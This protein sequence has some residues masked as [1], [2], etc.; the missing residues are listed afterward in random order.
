M[1]EQPPISADATLDPPTKAGRGRGRNAGAIV[2]ASAVAALSSLVITMF[3]NWTLDRPNDHSDY[4]EFIA[5]WSLLF[6][7][8]G[9][10]AG[11]QNE[12]TRAVGAARLA[13]SRDEARDPGAP[14]L[15]AGLVLGL[16]AAVLVVVS[17]PLWAPQMLPT[18]TWLVVALIA[19]ATLLYGG[20]ISL[21]GAL[22]GNENWGLYAALMAAE[23]LFRLIAV[24]AVGAL[25]GSLCGLEIATISA[26]LV[27]LVLL[28]A[29]PTS[30]QA[31][32]SRAD[33]GLGRL[34]TNQL[35]TIIAAAATAVLITGFPAVMNLVIPHDPSEP[36]MSATATALMLTRSPIM[37]PLLA[38]QGVAISNFLKQGGGVLRG[39]V[40]PL[41][42]LGLVGLIAAP[43]AAWLGPWLLRVLFS[44]M[45]VGRW[46]FVGLVIA[47]TIVAWLT[48]TGTAILAIGD[49][50]GY[51]AGWLL[52]AVVAVALLTVPLSI[53][54]RVILALAVG[55]LL[56]V[57]LHLM[58]IHRRSRRLAVATSTDRPESP[59]G[60]GQTVQPT[61]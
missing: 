10:I 22:A 49:H 58:R 9:V 43:L 14:V 27:W 30:R 25:I 32:G 38:F 48:L 19:L 2:A 51:L 26:V 29:S 39:L 37:I 35:L 60:Y 45:Q 31:A 56:G 6:G 59:D 34:L 21:S 17:A 52:A 3:A 57:G 13:R 54:G 7:V 12:I 33:V 24:A 20:H 53:P 1:T 23:A 50:A 46:T 41:G 47:S 36:T 42:A 28:L 44:G 61:P 11:L 55:P 16:V 5:F 40:K 15:L 4:N 18:N 8:Y